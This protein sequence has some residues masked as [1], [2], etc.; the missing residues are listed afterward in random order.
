MRRAS[1]IRRCS[2]A[3]SGSTWSPPPLGCAPF[4]RASWGRPA[5]AP[6]DLLRSLV[7]M[8][9]AGFTSVSDWVAL[10][11]AEPFY[12]VISGFDPHDVPGVGT[13]Y[14]FMNRLLGGP[15][16]PRRRRRSQLTPARKQQ[17]RREKKR[18]SDK[19]QAIVAR[20][21]R[22]LQGEGRHWHPAPVETL[23]NQLLG[24]L[25]VKPAVQQGLLPAE[26]GVSG[27]GTKLA[28]FANSYGRKACA[29]PQRRCGCPRRFTD[30]EA[31]T[32][33]DAYHSRYVFGHTLYELVAWSH[34][35][36]VE[37]PLYV[38]R[39]TGARN[40]AVL[41][42]LAL[43]RSRALGYVRIQQACFDGTHDSYAFY[44]LAQ[45]W[46]IGLFI[47]LSGSPR[48]SAG[49]GDGGLDA[50]GTPLCRAGRRMYPD[51]YQSQYRRHRWRCPLKKGP[52]RGEVSRCPQWQAC[53]TAPSGRIV[54]THPDRDLRVHG[55][56]PRGTARWQAVYDRRTA[57][58]RA[59]ARQSYHLGLDR[60]RTRGGNR[61]LFRGF[62]TA[63]AQHLITWQ[64]HQ[65]AT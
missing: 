21:A 49:G 44:E 50:D 22:A 10:M 55:E 42:P 25:C 53:S 17:L 46:E 38:M 15:P 39:A 11:R 8:T 58:E 64:A 34:G 20:L 19:H 29:C 62:L 1:N 57:S 18:P 6:E 61:W 24:E 23:L 9:L 2:L 7:A 12:A 33:Y 54:Y 32:G 52:E 13:F 14:D 31:S 56:P 47:P 45:A 30:A 60:T 16:R 48:Q 37:L 28:T 40:D 3:Y 36:K 51:G 35:S 59:Y 4:Y 27:D 43:A 41:G 26:V 5:R 65:P 63:V